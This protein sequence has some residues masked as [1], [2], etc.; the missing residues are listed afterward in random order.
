MSSPVRVTEAVER[1]KA[2]FLEMPGTRI[3]SEDASRLT[4]L[5]LETCVVVLKALEDAGFLARTGVGMFVRRH[6]DSPLW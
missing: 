5:E 6:L 4:G 1:L 3:T 2:V